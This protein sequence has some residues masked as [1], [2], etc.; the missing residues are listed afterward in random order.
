MNK[1]PLI[2]A[3]YQAGKIDSRI[4]RGGWECFT[5]QVVDNPLPGI[6]RALVI[7][8][9]DMRGTIY[10]LYD[11]SEQI[12]VSPWNWWGDV[13]VRKQEGVWALETKKVQKS[14]SVR[15]RGIFIND[16]QPALTNWI[17]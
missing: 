8:G 14:P 1:S 9:S 3:L 5:S 4:I 13:P 15:Y 10:G 16:E 12:G 2:R 11:V 17:K 6:D 7:V